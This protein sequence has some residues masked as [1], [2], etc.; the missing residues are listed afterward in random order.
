MH[1]VLYTASSSQ[2]GSGEIPAD[3]DEWEDVEEV[4][5][6]CE[7]EDSQEHGQP[8]DESYEAPGE[9]RRE[10][11]FINSSHQTCP[12]GAAIIYATLNSVGVRQG[13]ALQG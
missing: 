12:P 2:V 4:N 9:S 3:E 1:D 13:C 11:V 8:F 10:I 6:V 5:E 7:L